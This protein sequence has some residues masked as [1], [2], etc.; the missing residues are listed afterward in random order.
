MP[1]AAYALRLHGHMTNVRAQAMPFAA[2][3]AGMPSARMPP[4][5]PSPGLPKVDPAAG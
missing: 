3:A 5:R 2:Y 4:G 1:F